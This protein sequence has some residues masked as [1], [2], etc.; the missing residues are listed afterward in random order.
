MYLDLHRNPLLHFYL[1]SF[2]NPNF[3]LVLLY[4]NPCSSFI[5]MPTLVIL[6]AFFKAPFQMSCLLELVDVY[7]SFMLHISYGEHK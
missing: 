7:M 4:Q 2:V 6:V 3:N 5:V 1:A